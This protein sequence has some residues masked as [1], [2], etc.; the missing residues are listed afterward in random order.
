M[1]EAGLGSRDSRWVDAG[2]GRVRLEVHGNL[3]GEIIQLHAG[4]SWQ[5]QVKKMNEIEVIAIRP[6]ER[7]A[8]HCLTEYF[9]SLHRNCEKSA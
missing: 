1:D 3:L 9:L 8:K 4:G 5:V 7:A 6:D 2:C